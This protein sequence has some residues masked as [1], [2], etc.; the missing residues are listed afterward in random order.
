MQ[1]IVLDTNIAAP[2]DRCFLLSLSIDLHTTSTAQTEERAIAGVTSGIIGPGERVTWRGRHFGI[3]LTHQSVISAYD[4]PYFFEDRMIHGVFAYFEH[5][6]YFTANADHTT[7]R[8][9]L[10]F[11]APLGWLGR[12]VDRLVLRPYLRKFLLERNSCIRSTAES[13]DER[14]RMYLDGY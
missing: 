6:H 10:T 5:R 7:M 1:T 8:D 13:Q 12:A 11:A 4:R 3:M 14:W 9:E 2:I